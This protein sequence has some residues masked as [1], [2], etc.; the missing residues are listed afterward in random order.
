MSKTFI[1]STIRNLVLALRPFDRQ[2]KEHIDFTLQWIDS[3]AGLFRLAKPAN[4]PIHLVSYFVVVDPKTDE[5]LLVDHKNAKLWLPPGGHVEPEEHPEAAVEREVME[6]LGIAANFFIRDPFFLTV[7][8]TV[9]SLEPHVDIS[10]WYI[11]KGEI[12]MEFNYDSEEFEKIAWFK[13]E[14]IPYAH[15]DPHLKRFMHKWQTH[16]SPFSNHE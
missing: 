2:E 9:G 7:T 14:N 6:E 12:G 10:L 8:E 13:S 4:P 16:F 15:S 5:F 3:G 11:L 1:R